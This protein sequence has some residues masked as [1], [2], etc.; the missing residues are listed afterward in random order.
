MQMN[1]N[2]VGGKKEQ[3]L[4]DPLVYMYGCE[5]KLELGIV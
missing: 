5:C 2:D 4:L 1:L 3:L